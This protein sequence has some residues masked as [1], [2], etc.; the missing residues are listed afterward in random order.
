[1]W[2]T[3]LP[4]SRQRSM[5]FSEQLEQVADHDHL[6]G[7]VLAAVQVAEQVHH[8]LVGLALVLVQPA[9]VLLDPVQIRPAPQP[10]DHLAQRLGRL[11]QQAGLL[12][13]QLGEAAGLQE[14]EPLGELLG[15]L[16]DSRHG[17]GQVLDVLALQRRDQRAA[18]QRGDLLVNLLLLPPALDESL[19]DAASWRRMIS[20]ISAST[21]CR[22]SSALASSRSKNRCPLLRK[23]WRENMERTVYQGRQWETVIIGNLERRNPCHHPLPARPRT[24]KNEGGCGQRL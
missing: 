17:V 21:D 14:Q 7:V 3:I 11:L 10:P 2:K 5:T 23:R 4:A 1:M 19:Q 24:H 22:A 8:Q 6:H 15:H 13:E 20:S 16:G 9:V 18:K 12:A